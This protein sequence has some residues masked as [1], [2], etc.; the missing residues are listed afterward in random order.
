MGG[1]VFAGRTAGI[2]IEN[3]EPTLS[4]YFEELK[5]L[6]P[7][8]SKI[9]DQH[10][11]IPLGSVGK[12]VVSGDIDLGVNATD[13]IDNEMTDSSIEEWGIDPIDVKAEFESLKKR[14]R[15]A[16]LEQLRMKAFLKMLTLYI[17]SHAPNLY[18]DEKKVTTGNIFGLYPQINKQEQKVGIGVQIDWMVGDLN[19]LKFSYY[20]AAYPPSSNVK[21]LHRTQLLL[22]AFQVAKL[23]FD[24]ISGVKDKETKQ[25]VATNPAEALNIL[26]Q[27]L[28]VKITIADADD[29][30]KLHNL[31]ESKMN[32]EQYNEMINIYF[33][34]LDSTRVDIPDNLQNQWRT[35]QAILGLTGKFLP[36]T[37]KLKEVQ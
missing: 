29:Y 8:K 17:N 22:S 11:F 27:R 16:T 21:G 30:Y 9:F 7:K 18:C 34:I 36:D 13:I 3:I 28:N 12:K 5:R 24:H 33:K 25:I 10:H 4:A 31:L 14:A 19:W 2:S 6:F 23:S 32:I 1:N 15:T 35:K 37:S 26:N 20:S